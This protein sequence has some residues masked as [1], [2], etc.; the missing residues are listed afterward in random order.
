ML[1]HPLGGDGLPPADPNP[2]PNPY[3]NPNPNPNPKQVTGFHQQ[4]DGDVRHGLAEHV[5]QQIAFEQQQQAHWRKLLE[6]FTPIETVPHSAGVAASPPRPSTS[7]AGSGVR[8]AGRAGPS[9]LD[10][11]F[12]MA[13]IPP[14]GAVG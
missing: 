10:A 4:T 5:R 9:A 7:P 3:P 14:D 12:A 11:S 2:N 8:G 13:E 1:H 6:V